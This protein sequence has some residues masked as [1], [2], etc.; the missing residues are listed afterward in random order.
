MKTF[1][2]VTTATGLVLAAASDAM[3]CS[4]KKNVTA[5]APMT[6]IITADEKASDGATTPRLPAGDQKKG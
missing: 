3:A 6:P 4:F 1:L 2:A 5:E